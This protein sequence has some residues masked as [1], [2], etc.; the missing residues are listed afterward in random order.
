MV[1]SRWS[2]RIDAASALVRMGSGDN[3]RR[4]AGALICGCLSPAPLIALL[5]ATPAAAAQETREALIAAEQADKATRLAPS[6]PSTAE[7][8]LMAAKHSLL[9]EPSGFYP[10]FDSVYSGGGFTLGGGYRRFTGD[11]TNVSIAG[12]YSAKGYK[13]IEAGAWSPGHRAGLLDVRVRA[14]WRDATQAAYYGLGIDSAPEDASAFRMQ[15]A[16]AGA[17]LTLWGRRRFFLRAGAAYEDYTLKAPT[18]DLPSVEDVYT[19]DAA[20][21]VGADPAFLRTSASIGYDSRPAADYARRGGLAEL[22]HHRYV[23]RDGVHSFNRLDAEVVKHIPI[24][25]ENW[26]ISL[27]GLLQ[28]ITNDHAQAPYFLLP[29]LGSGSTLR[30]YGSWR[31]RDR[32]AALT[33]AE[34]RWIPSRL[35]LDM[36]LFYDAGT[37]APAFD[38]IALR[39]F[40]SDVGVGVRFH[41]P[42]STP[43]R[44]DLAH[45]REGMHLVFAASAAF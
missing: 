29:S 40:V 44:I 15:Q 19:P 41:G 17:D 10:Y 42:V 9:E 16:Y 18:G 4:A 27:R 23:D 8:L 28:T 14:G 33:S 3:A 6:T 43:L 24:L 21:G 20:P 13:L 11:R 35:A 7:R 1:R 32:H 31:F 36:A 22:S 37:V 26:V 30:G 12:L 45:G 5:L 2:S 25:R 38:Q 39:S 34:F